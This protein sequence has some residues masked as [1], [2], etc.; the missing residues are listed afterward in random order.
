MECGNQLRYINTKLSSVKQ[1]FRIVSHQL[2]TNTKRRKRGLINGI[3]SA[4]TWLFG[5]PNADDA[6]FYSDSINSL[7]ANQKQTHTLMQQ[8]VSIISETIT[9]FNKSLYRMNENVDILNKNLKQFNKI[10]NDIK[11]LATK[12]DVEIT[13]SNHMILLI[14]MTD[15]VNQLLENYVTDLSMIQNGLINFRTLPPEILY[16]ELQKLA[17]QFTLPIPLTMDNIY[18]YY[19]IM[20][21]QSFINNNILIIAFKIPLANMYVYDLYQIFSLPTPHVQDPQLFSYIEPMQPYIL[22]ST[23]RTTFLTLSDLNGCKNYLPTQW[24][25]TDTPPTKATTLDVCEIQLFMKTTTH[26]PPT[27][28][29]R[30]ILA[31]FEIWHKLSPEEWLFAFTKP[32]QLTIVCHSHKEPKELLISKMGILLLSSDCK[33]Y[34]TQTIL[35]TQSSLG[36]QNLTHE[37]PLTDISHDDCCVRLKENI[38]LSQVNLEPI[39]LVNLDLHELKFAQHK[40]NQFDEQ[41]QQQLNKPFIIQKSYWYTTVLS[42]IG[43]IILTTIIYRLAKWCGI[44]NIFHILCRFTKRSEHGTTHSNPCLQ[45][46]NQCYNKPHRPANVHYD[47]NLQHLTYHMPAVLPT[48]QSWPSA[49]EQT[50]SQEEASATSFLRRSQRIN[51]R[52]SVDPS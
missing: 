30:N 32:T 45:I 12:L 49:E 17:T 18:N 3:G 11:D 19:K 16:F 52:I 22:I 15:E 47:A 21:L 41:L 27:C 2:N 43:G 29:T 38:T 48:T 23:T 44:P 39:N 26:I 1:L 5:N 10:S 51:S 33:A 20:S 24:L 13:L 35:E 8:Q 50:R 36:S 28:K 31:N 40:L 37:I 46:F 34:T 42:I 25:C 7:V 6:T 14:E 4:I 9:N